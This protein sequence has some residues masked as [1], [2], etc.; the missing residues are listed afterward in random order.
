[1]AAAA[2]YVDRALLRIVRRFRE[3]ADAVDVYREIA[4]RAQ[5]AYETARLRALLQLDQF[6][7]FTDGRGALNPEGRRLRRLMRVARHE[8]RLSTGGL[9][10]PDGRDHGDAVRSRHR[11]GERSAENVRAL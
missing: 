1:M 6:E 5:L 8:R 2:P 11:D 4:Q 7:L 3:D 10:V 9:G